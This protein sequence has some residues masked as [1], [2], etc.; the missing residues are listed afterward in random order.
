MKRNARPSLTLAVVKRDDDELT[1]C[2]SLDR[3]NLTRCY[4]HRLLARAR[5]FWRR[6]YARRSYH[7]P[8]LRC[9]WARA[10]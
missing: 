6:G 1:G 8:R 10:R 9:P 2:V 7:R 3:D 5:A 4:A